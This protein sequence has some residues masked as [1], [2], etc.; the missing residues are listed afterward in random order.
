MKLAAWLY[1]LLDRRIGISKRFDRLYALDK[2]PFGCE[3]FVYERVKSA[4]L[5]EYIHGRHFNHIL[6]I[7]CGTGTITRMLGDYGDD[8]TAIDF[9]SMAI[10]LAKGFT[11]QNNIKYFP[12]DIRMLEFKE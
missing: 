4:S 12:A 6:D 2:D 10:A 1:Y 8:I 3:T 11:S 5:L 7:G 9:S